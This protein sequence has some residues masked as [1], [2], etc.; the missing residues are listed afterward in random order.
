VS[1]ASNHGRQHGNSAPI[2]AQPSTPPAKA[3]PRA[4][5]P[6]LNRRTCADAGWHLFLTPS[7]RSFGDKIRPLAGLSGT[8]EALAAAKAGDM[9]RAD[10][11]ELAWLNTWGPRPSVEQLTGSTDDR[12]GVRA[13]AIFRAHGGPIICWIVVEVSCWLCFGRIARHPRCR[14]RHCDGSGYDGFMDALYYYTD[15]DL[16]L[17]EVPKQ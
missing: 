12:L 9:K 5:R 1:G 8:P 2:L 11:L 3:E 7:E 4:A 14:N 6:A 10:E 15:P 17:V 13:A 16:N